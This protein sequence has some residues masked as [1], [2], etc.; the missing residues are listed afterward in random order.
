V[1][2]VL[3]AMGAHSIAL[4]LYPGLVTLVAFGLIVEAA[5]S[6]LSRSSQV[7]PGFRIARPQI[8]HVAVALLAVLAVVQTAAPF[9]PV[10]PAERNVIIAVAAL[11]FT[12][13]A[14]MALD[15]ELV[16]KPGLMFVIQSC[17][18]LAVLGPAI[19]PQSLR[20]QVLGNVLVPELMPVKVAC[21]FLYLLCLPPLL[22]LW[23]VAPPA[24]RRTRPRFNTARALMWFPYC[25]LFATLFF[26][27]QGDDVVGLLRF[28]GLVVATAA[29][30]ILAGF[31]L[32]RRGAERA[33]GLYSR[34]VTPYS[35]LVLAL[36][37]GTLIITR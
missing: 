32:A 16:A 12:A 1:T 24:D 33:R 36:V 2:Q 22:R 13:W 25:A 29:V 37:I 34:A 28:A 20:P 27:P 4:L 35:V 17:W 30:C 11:G 31:L 21:G 26:P 5:W 14:E 10:A 8:V 6:A 18:V 15:P 9:N 23:P 19:E 7:L 3:S